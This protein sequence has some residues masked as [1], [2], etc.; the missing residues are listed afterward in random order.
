MRGGGEYNQDSFVYVAKACGDVEGHAVLS[1]GWDKPRCAR[2]QAI[3]SQNRDDYEVQ[4]YVR[5]GGGSEMWLH[6]RVLW[7]CEARCEVL[8]AHGAGSGEHEDKHIWCTVFGK[9][10]ILC[11]LLY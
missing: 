11:A 8:A 2:W 1:D 9:T 10:Q 4:G 5:R 6:A 3:Y 7:G